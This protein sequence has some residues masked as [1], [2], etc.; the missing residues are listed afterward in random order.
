MQKLLGLATINVAS[1]IS[2][3]SI[4]VIYNLYFVVLKHISIYGFILWY[5]LKYLRKKIQLL[6]KIKVIDSIV[7]KVT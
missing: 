6:K 7:I 4:L 5:N 2:L 3:H 1:G